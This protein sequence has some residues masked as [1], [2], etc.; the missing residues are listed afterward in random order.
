MVDWGLEGQL[1]KV[2]ETSSKLLVKHEAHVANPSELDKVQ[3]R[4]ISIASLASLILQLVV[5]HATGDFLSDL[6][7][8]EPFEDGKRLVCDC[9][10]LRNTS[11]H[12]GHFPVDGSHVGNRAEVEVYADV[13]YEF[14][15]QYV[16]VSEIHSGWASIVDGF[17]IDRCGR[18]ILS[19]ERDDEGMVLPN[20]DICRIRVPFD[21]L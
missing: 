18:R 8:K 6:N 13:L 12:V 4:P 5:K 11:D 3:M 2:T 9:L 17:G 7:G 15:W 21:D 14:G 1:S 19:L 20:D 16:K 10:V